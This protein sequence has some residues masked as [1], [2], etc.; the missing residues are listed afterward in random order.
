MNSFTII[1]LIALTLSYGVQFWL[2]LRQAE[3]V[4]QHRDRVPDAFKDRVSLAAHQKAADYTLDKNKLGNIDG[5]VGIVFLVWLTL[6]GGIN[7]GFSVWAN[8]GWS[9]LMTGLAAVA[10]IL[11]S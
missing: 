6:G 1:F 5:V 7:L 10:T 2:S 4:R 3:H 11:W 9:P 8:Q